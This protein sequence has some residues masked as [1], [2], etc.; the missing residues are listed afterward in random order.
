[1]MYPRHSELCA[2]APPHTISSTFSIVLCGRP[3]VSLSLAELTGSEARVPSTRFGRLTIPTRVATAVRK[4]APPA[5]D[6]CKG[7]NWAVHPP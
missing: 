1:M 7:A 4:S 5:F 3:R 6:M 2:Y